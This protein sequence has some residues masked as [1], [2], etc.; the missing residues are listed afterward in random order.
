[1]LVEGLK[2]LEESVITNLREILELTDC[3]FSKGGIPVKIIELIYLFPNLKGLRYCEIHKLDFPSI[4]LK[5]TLE[6]QQDPSSPNTE[7]EV[8][9]EKN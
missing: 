1:M 8:K 4:I 6:V 7:E 3:P 5:L 2:N 9:E